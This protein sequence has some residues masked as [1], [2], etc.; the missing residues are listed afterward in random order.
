MPR[1]FIDQFLNEPGWAKFDAELGYTLQNCFTPFGIE[2]TGTI[3]T[4]QQ[5]GARSG[6][7]Y[8]GRKPRIH[9]YG[10]S[11]TEC[12]QVS[13]GETWQE[14]LGAHLGEPIANFGVGGY[15]VYQAYRRML[16]NEARGRGA[17]YVILYVW[18]DDPTRSLMRARWPVVYPVFGAI[19]RSFRLFHGNPWAH[20]ELD[21]ETGEFV[22]KPNLL[23][24]PES[25][26]RLCDPQWLVDDAARRSRRAARRL[27]GRA[28]VG[29]AGRDRGARPRA[30]R[31]ARARARVRSSTGMRRIC[32]S[33]RRGC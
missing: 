22:E 5:D 30:H 17:D 12:S 19:V 28:A 27:R 20:V 26:Y 25:L 2:N 21:L 23:P 11:F 3:E 8:A 4:F 29:H 31:R 1:S 9:A 13:D 18:G 32:A 15:G 24:T 6:F 16:R 14:Y 33:T 10:D 7:M